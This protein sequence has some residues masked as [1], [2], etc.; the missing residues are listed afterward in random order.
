MQFTDS[1]WVWYVHKNLLTLAISH[2][3]VCNLGEGCLAVGGV[4]ECTVIASS[5][6]YMGSPQSSVTV[7]NNE[8]WALTDG[9][10]PTEGGSEQ[11][12]KV[13]GPEWTGALLYTSHDHNQNPH[14]VTIFLETSVLFQASY[15]LLWEV[16]VAVGRSYRTK[17]VESVPC[18]SQEDGSLAVTSRT[19]ELVS[20]SGYIDSLFHRCSGKNMSKGWSHVRLDG[21]NIR[22]KQWC[23]L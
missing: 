20:Q 8:F 4:L 23:Y 22:K 2:A 9:Q 21:I 13:W 7:L 12:W 6:G 3:R 10:W 15:L 11:H 16:N 14:D 5:V 18:Q 19:T 17:E 1:T